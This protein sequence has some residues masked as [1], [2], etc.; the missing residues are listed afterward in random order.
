VNGARIG[1]VTQSF[2]MI[3]VSL[4]VATPNS[5]ISRARTRSASGPL[6]FLEVAIRL[7]ASDPTTGLAL[8]RLGGDRRK[9]ARA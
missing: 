9:T 8:I 6:D 1:L 4:C 5:R 2:V 7:A 3:R